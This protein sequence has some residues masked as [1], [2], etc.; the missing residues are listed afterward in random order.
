MLR[1][2]R[3]IVAGLLLGMLSMQP[4]ASMDYPHSTV[5]G[6]TCLTCHDIHGGFAKLLRIA[7]PHAPQD[8]DDTPANNLCWSCHNN[9]VAPFKNPHSSEQIDEDYG[10]WAIECVVC[11]NPHK[12]EQRWY[13]GSQAHLATGTVTTVTTTSLYSVG[14][15]WT[16]DEFADLIVVPNTSQNYN[17][18][19]IVSNTA[20]TLTISAGL[21]G[22]GMD[23]SKVSPGDTFAIIYGKLI[24]GPNRLSR[25]DRGSPDTLPGSD[26]CSVTANVFSCTN[27]IDTTVKFLRD[28][29]AGVGGSNEHSFAGDVDGD[30]LYQ[31]P[32]E[33][34]HTRTKH[35]RNNND[36]PGDADHTHNVGLKCTQCHKHENGFLPLGAGA[37]EVH[38]TKE[39]GPKITCSDGNWGCHGTFVPGSNYPNEVIFA[40]GKPLCTGRPGAAC[41]N[42]GADTE[43]EVCANCHGEGS[44]LAKYYFFRPGSSEG[45]PG[46]WI[47]P[48]SGP[49][50]W[51]DTWLGDIGEAK[52]CGSCHNDTDSTFVPG[53]QPPGQPPN[54]VGDLNLDTGIST[55]GFF[56]NGH[57]KTAGNYDRL[58]WQNDT[59]TGNPAANKLCSDCHEYTGTHFNNPDPD[60]KRLKAG[61]E[62]DAASTVCD[63][64]HGQEGGDTAIADP[65]YYTTHAAFENSAHGS[66]S[67]SNLKCTDCHD[68]HGAANQDVGTNGE[69]NQA[70]TKGYKQA[71]CYR[72]HSDSG[73]LMVVKNN[74]VSG[75]AYADDIEQAFNLTT[76]HPL[77]TGYAI[78]GKNYTLNC[79]NCHNVH[80]VTGKYWEADQNK[81]PVTRVS[82]PSNPEGNLTIWGDEASEKMDAYAGSASGVYRT[83][84]VSVNTFDGSELPAYPSFCLD[85][86]ENPINAISAKDWDDNPHGKKTAGI[87]SLSQGT[88]PSGGGKFYG[89]SSHKDCPDWWTCGKALDW[90]DDSCDEAAAA[91]GGV[92]ECWPVKPKGAGYPNHLKGNFN[93]EERNAGINF[94]LSCTDCHDPHGS[95]K[96]KLMRK[97]LNKWPDNPDDVELADDQQTW[98]FV[99]SG[100]Q[101]LC[102][103]CHYINTSE[104]QVYPGWH[105][106]GGLGGNCKVGP[107]HQPPIGGHPGFGHDK[108]WGRCHT[109]TWPGDGNPIANYPATFHENRRMGTSNTVPAKVPGMVGWYKFENNLLDAD[110]WNMDGVWRLT[111]SPNGGTY[112]AGK[113]GNAAVF[114]DSP[115]EMGTTDATW[116][117]CAGGDCGTGGSN[118]G[119]NTWKYSEMKYNSSIEA[120]VNPTSNP[121]DNKSRYVAAKHT[122]WDGGYALQLIVKN[123]EYRVGYTTNMDH[124][125]P[126]DQWDWSETSCNGLRGAYSTAAIPMNEWTHVAATFDTAGPDGNVGDLSVGRIRIYVNGVDVTTSDYPSWTC[127]AQPQAGEDHMTPIS[128][129]GLVYPSRCSWCSSALSVGGVNWS[130]PDS[131]FVGMIDEFKLWNVTK[132]ATYFSESIP[133]MITKVE[134]QTGHDRLYVTLSEGAYANT[135]ATGDLQP[136]DF[137]LVDSDN[138]R[139]ISSVI[140]TAGSTAVEL[141]LSAP[142]DTDNDISVDTLAAAANSI[143]DAAGASPADTNAVTIEAL[144]GASITKVEGIVGSDQL[145]VTF[146]GGV[147]SNAGMSGALVNTDFTYTDIDNS[148]TVTGVAHVAGDTTAILTLS[149]VLDGTNDVDVD[150]LAA[151]GS[152]IYDG[153]DNLM[154]IEAVTVAGQTPPTITSLTGSTG[155]DQLTATFSENIY[156]N[157]DHTGPLL[158]ADFTP[159]GLTVNQVQHTAGGLK[160]Y[161]TLSA[162]LTG[163]EF[164]SGSYTIAAAS[165][166]VFSYNGAPMGTNAYQITEDTTPFISTAEGVVGSD[167]V[168][169]TFVEAVYAN[170]DQTGD[171]QITDL[172]LV[173]SDNGRSITAVSHTA[174]DTIAYL[175]LSAALDGTADIGVDTVAAAGGA[176][177]RADGSLMGTTPKIIT[178]QAVPTILSATGQVGYDKIEI[179][180][181]EGVWTNTGKTGVL[182]NT[183]FAALDLGGRTIDAASHVAGESTALLTLSSALINGDLSAR[184]IGANSNQ[185]FNNINNAVS[186]ASASIT[187]M[188]SP[189]IQTVEGYIGG[190][191][192]YVTFTEGVSSDPS[193]PVS[194]DSLFGSFVLSGAATATGISSITHVGGDRYA[195]FT[196]NAPMDA[197]D[198][199]VATL[200]PPAAAIFNKDGYPAGPTGVALADQPIPVIAEVNGSV[201]YDRVVVRFSQ[202]VFANPGADPNDGLQIGDLIW[203]DQTGS[204]LT[205]ASVIH[206]PGVEHY[207][208]L[209]DFVY[210]TLSGPLTSN[211]VNSNNATFAANGVYNFLDNMATPTAV[212]G[213]QITPSPATTIE[214]VT[215]SVGMTELEV[216]FKHWVASNPGMRDGLNSADFTLTD[217]SGNGVKTITAVQHRPGDLNA[218]LTLSAPLESDDL[219]SDTLEAKP[220]EI[221]NNY[222]YPVDTTA[223][224]ITSRFGSP[225]LIKVL[226]KHNQQGVVVYFNQ[227]VYANA[228]GTGA[229][230][231]ADFA[232]T[233]VL[234]AGDNSI[235]TVDHTAG[236][237]Q[238][239]LH[240]TTNRINLSGATGDFLNDQI[241][242]AANS[243]F[244]AYGFPA[245]TTP[246]TMIEGKRPYLTIAEAVD[247]STKILVKFSERVWNN[248]DAPPAGVLDAADFVYVS[249]IGNNRTISAVSHAVGQ[250]YAVLTMS[251][252]TIATDFG[253]A[254]V[255]ANGHNAIFPGYDLGVNGGTGQRKYL[256][257][258]PAPFIGGAQGTIGS[259]KVVVTF[260]EGVRGASGNLQAS[261][262]TFVD[263]NTSGNSISSVSHTAGDAVAYLIMSAA[264]QAGDLGSDTL[265]ATANLKS[266]LIENPLN[267][268]PVAIRS[269]APALMAA[270]GSAGSTKVEVTFGGPV[271]SNSNGTGALAAADFSY[272]DTKADNPITISAVSHS[273]GDATALLTM[274]GNL[275]GDDT[276]Y[277]DPGD[278]KADA[279][280]AA[281]GAIFDYLGVALGTTSV[282]VTPVSGPWITRVEGAATLDKVQV[283]FSEGVYSSPGRSDALAPTDFVFTDLDDGR[284]ITSVEHYAGSAAALLTLSSP[285]DRDA[286]V[287][288]D[289][290]AAGINEIFGKSNDPVRTNPVTMVGNDCPAGGFR[291]DF[292]ETAGSATVQ[293]TTGL[294]NG[295]VFSGDPS[296]GIL[297]DGY[298]TSDPLQQVQSYIEF[299]QNTRCFKTPRAYTIETRVFYEDVDI[300]YGDVYPLN[301]V[302]DDYDYGG[303]TGKIP[304]GTPP[305]GKN[306]TNMMNFNRGVNYIQF[307]SS[308]NNW[309]GDH[310]ADRKDKSKLQ[311]RH[312]TK[313]QKVCDGTYPGDTTVSSPSTSEEWVTDRYSYEITKGH[314]YT[315]RVVFNTDKGYT[316]F[317]FFGR[318]EGTDGVGTDAKWSGYKNISNPPPETGD[319]AWSTNPGSEFTEWDAQFGIGDDSIHDGAHDVPGALY[320][321]WIM[322]KMDWLSFKPMADYSGVDEGPFFGNT[323][324][325]ADAGPDQGV[326]TG[327]LVILDGSGSADAEGDEFTYSWI[328][329]SKPGGSTAVPSDPAIV[330]PT[331][332]ADVTGVY[333]VELTAEDSFGASTTDSVTINV[334]P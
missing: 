121:S 213:V 157:N 300:D 134:G 46:L 316:S 92:N 53:P 245:G 161:I 225:G 39:F 103:Q 243:I 305:D 33:V 160:A 78:S 120:W 147:Y 145:W 324:P 85:C 231:P 312:T 193:S 197:G 189:A 329:T 28:F 75:T 26:T 191:T 314:W 230:Q 15:T 307:L 194:I 74:A 319:C 34:C 223:V 301:D 69:P 126:T 113:T 318:D 59:E 91:A 168:K 61:Y 270:E 274:S 265:A 122:Y 282:Y 60:N 170:S 70:M 153:S 177:Y 284:T 107:C 32:C 25:P 100:T 179:T 275:I 87:T 12:Q 131:N 68:P 24:Y 140:H 7:N 222:D 174:G 203:D 41:P 149:S 37:H 211:H 45:D 281:S 54:V 164:G 67:K 262:F 331:F 112:A 93:M 89:G 289:S 290:V 250:D 51:D 83:P 244:G 97:S 52:Y 43:T 18:Y 44:L 146:S 226:G 175:T 291:L 110:M 325:V 73:D 171:L 317:D 210:V 118:S 98:G 77:G 269:A 195:T 188:P 4:Q 264:I 181:D 327:A 303:P 138:S 196:M 232:Y 299:N 104:H 108:C 310:T 172:T 229:L 204:A 183:D 142:L 273:A 221:F 48:Q 6:F 90:G 323:A 3:Q 304:G 79:V 253:T 201:G 156:S 295:T 246:T 9:V 233:E 261:D 65:K 10:Q 129:V 185:V 76:H 176:V 258:V 217:V 40:D 280:A 192:L 31:G 272:T 330:S 109:T 283:N 187:E 293:D 242:P 315:F 1:T 38:I 102:Y 125:G 136:A 216:T 124:G 165:S 214:T 180:F 128:D 58:S 127:W 255:R 13:Y 266:L 322:G 306:V 55:Y 286:D 224:A 42:T 186:N 332:T 298:F 326:T 19:R 86:H 209:Q 334:T 151:A 257:K 21:S 173:D 47:T 88:T 141:V 84:A 63:N 143:Y 333:T 297:G 321:P 248:R 158:I 132:D 259:S 184:N 144:P 239:V 260:S 278:P 36:F 56:F 114:N 320:T 277:S 117:T 35:H 218:T 166:A 22:D 163:T 234:N 220:V 247:G 287:G 206:S 254:S 162:P 2:T 8:I 268:T 71:L 23:M 328:I 101:G 27:R 279:V 199:G 263:G 313:H 81:T 105:G 241:G 227:P 155:S 49:Y 150:T 198:I 308:K 238:A 251:A 64:C 119:G 219:F 29:R 14:A 11:H 57:G 115:V 200:A 95:Q 235:A 228:D 30:G 50:T 212:P 133:P 154:G 294:L 80:L 182:V 94:V 207:K 66:D 20:D 167:Q 99:G 288:V 62:N 72:C 130:S 215:G 240:F 237:D 202:E 152:E 139:T 311:L 285:L 190:T 302:D 271:Y 296:F 123:G 309:G 106:P 267:T 16:V 137:T 178:A 5:N 116:S 249:D 159:T 111:N 169:I 252:P 135:N 276:D 148:R 256:S 292:N 17:N 96:Y 82:T 205:V 236:D 208:T